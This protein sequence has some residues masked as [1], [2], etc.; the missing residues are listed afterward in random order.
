MVIGALVSRSLDEITVTVDVGSTRATSPRDDV[1]FTASNSGAGSK[2]TSTDR[3]PA[4]TDVVES[5]KP[6]TVTTTV[7]PVSAVTGT[8]KRPFASVCVSV[9]VLPPISM[10]TSALGTD[11]PLGSIT[12]PVN[13]SADCA[14]SVVTVD[15]AITSAK[16]AARI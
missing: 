5:A 12:R 3:A 15:V 10:R 14:T 11:A 1:T 16:S 2:V 9:T 8:S 6:G 13:R 4:D 7:R